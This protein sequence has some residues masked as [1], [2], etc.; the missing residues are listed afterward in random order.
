[1]PSIERIRPWLLP[2]G[3][4]ACLVVI[5]MPLPAPLMDLL[6]AGTIAL[7]DK[8]QLIQDLATAGLA[9]IEAG[10]FVNPRWVPQMADSEAVFRGLQRR[11][12]VRYA[13]LTPNMKG[14]ERALDAGA[15]EVAVFA[16]A[17]ESF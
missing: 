17:S 6:L 1:M 9:V 11:A 15:D 10:S 7:A 8:V 2:V 4:M 3:V 12:G 16:A 14:F 13:A 5:L